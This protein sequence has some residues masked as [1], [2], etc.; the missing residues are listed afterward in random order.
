MESLRKSSN[1]S[2]VVDKMMG[3]DGAVL[4][5]MAAR[6]ARAVDTLSRLPA[7]ADARP[8]RLAGGL[9]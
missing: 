5:A 9:S 8:A 2:G 4:Q 3:Y 6:L 1:A 7:T